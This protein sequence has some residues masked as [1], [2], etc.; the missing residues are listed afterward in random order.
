MD[1]SGVRKLRNNGF[2]MIDGD[3]DNNVDDAFVLS[4]A[5]GVAFAS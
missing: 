4:F 2:S 3:D 1:A 5:F